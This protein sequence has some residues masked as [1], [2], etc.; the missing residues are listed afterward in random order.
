MDGAQH[1]VLSLAPLVI[2]EHQPS[3]FKKKKKPGAAVTKKKRT[4]V[5]TQR[6]GCSSLLGSILE[7]SFRSRKPV[8]TK[9]ETTLELLGRENPMAILDVSLVT[10]MLVPYA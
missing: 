4:A 10:N 1:A 3:L 7:V 2:V 8:R 5:V 6:L 9:N